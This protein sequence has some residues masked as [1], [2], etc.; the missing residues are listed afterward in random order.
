MPT[1]LGVGELDDVSV[2]VGG[3]SVVGKA[4]QRHLGVVERGVAEVA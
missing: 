3:R 1:D 2:E 4:E